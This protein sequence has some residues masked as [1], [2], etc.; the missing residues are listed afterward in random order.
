M[1]G[2]SRRQR[3]TVKVGWMS[4]ATYNLIVMLDKLGLRST[5]ELNPVGMKLFAHARRNYEQ[6]RKAQKL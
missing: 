1:G 4:A 2:N 6:R 3:K 5:G